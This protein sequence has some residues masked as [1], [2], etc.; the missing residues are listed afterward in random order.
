MYDSDEVLRQHG[1]DPIATHENVE[2]MN[3]LLY[4]T[5]RKTPKD[6][7]ESIKDLRRDLTAQ[8]Q[9]LFPHNLLYH[10]MEMALKCVFLLSGD[11]L[12]YC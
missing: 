3:A 1:I 5:G 7:R 8:I 11:C 9:T 12:M 4:P 2:F 6:E 10:K